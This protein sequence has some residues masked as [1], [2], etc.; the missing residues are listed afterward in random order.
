MS[1]IVCLNKVFDRH[2]IKTRKAGGTDDAF[3]LIELCRIHHVEAHKIGNVTFAL[4]YPQVLEILE[5][6]GW[7]IEDQ[8]GRKR[9][10]RC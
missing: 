10:T 5:A 4:K 9:L 2:H 8:F 3:N 7:T 6:K 1:C